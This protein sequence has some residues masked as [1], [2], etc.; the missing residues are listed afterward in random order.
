MLN[1]PGTYEGMSSDEYTDILERSHGDLKASLHEAEQYVI[2]LEDLL[3]PVAGMLKVIMP[4]MLSLKMMRKYIENH[5]RDYN[6]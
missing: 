4:L 2:Y 6:G 1:I 3:S 5:L